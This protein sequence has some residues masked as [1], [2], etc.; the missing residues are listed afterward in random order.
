ML[1]G[2]KVKGILDDGKNGCNYIIKYGMIFCEKSDSNNS[3]ELIK[4][5]LEEFVTKYTY[6]IEVWE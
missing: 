1:K 6:F 5:S 3:D 4:I 2:G